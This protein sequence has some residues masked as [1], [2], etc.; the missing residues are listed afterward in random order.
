VNRA[1]RSAPD[2]APDRARILPVDKHLIGAL[3]LV[4]VT[5]TGCGS[6]AADT[7]EQA[8]EALES[9][10]ND[11]DDDAIKTLV[12]ADKWR[13]ARTFR[14]SLAAFAELDPRLGDLRYQVR[15]GE[16][17]DETETTATGE[18]E[19]LPIENYPD[20]L[21]D[22]A[23]TALDTTPAPLPIMLVHDNTVDLVKENGNWVAC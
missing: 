13:D 6:A 1:E 16:V 23:R 15:A 9:A 20:D 18:L 12:C 7:P 11:Q 17:R 4:A 22:E 8:L 21:S 2:P 14:S 3:G 19:P 5:L 10:T